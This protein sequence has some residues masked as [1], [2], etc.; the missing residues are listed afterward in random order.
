[1]VR[2]GLPA[3]EPGHFLR[4]ALDGRIRFPFAGLVS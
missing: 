1:M 4:P 3:F 2:G